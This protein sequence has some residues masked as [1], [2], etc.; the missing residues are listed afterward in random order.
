LRRAWRAAHVGAA[1]GLVMAPGD[2]AGVVFR[3]KSRRG[4]R[5]E[6]IRFLF[7]DLDGACWAAAVDRQF[8][9]DTI[10]G[11]SLLFRLLALIDLMTDT[12]WLRPFFSLSQ[13][14]GAVIDGKLMTVAA[15]QPLSET[16]AFEAAAFKAAMGLANPTPSFAPTQRQKIASGKSPARRKAAREGTRRGSARGSR[17][18]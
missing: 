3:R 4:R 15:A 10:Q 5:A 13:A 11:V 18:P 1:V 2:V 14:D 9:L 7:S 16:A 17:P 6:E 8:G 12:P